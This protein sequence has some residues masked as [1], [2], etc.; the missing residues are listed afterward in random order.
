M[1]TVIP[2]HSPSWEVAP[3]TKSTL[4]TP[5]TC[6]YCRQIVLNPGRW[7]MMYQFTNTQK[8]TENLSFGFVMRGANRGCLL[9]SLILENS[10]VALDRLSTD[11]YSKEGKLRRDFERRPEGFLLY[12]W[13]PPA[14]VPIEFGAV[15]QEEALKEYSFAMNEFFAIG[16]FR[17]SE[18]SCKQK[19]LQGS[20]STDRVHILNS[21]Q[22]T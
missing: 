8:K 19:S 6:E 3:E 5:H 11:A 17:Y 20:S 7:E 2:S 13:F 22:I 1:G 9:F 18:S 14:D 10:K 4:V 21:H 15:R 12:W 16:S